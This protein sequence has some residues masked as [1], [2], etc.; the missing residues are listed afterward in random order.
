MIG[1]CGS[2][3]LGSRKKISRQHAEQR[4]LHSWMERQLRLF[5]E[6]QEIAMAME[7]QR[8]QNDHDLLD[9]VAK[10]VNGAVRAIADLKRQYM[11]LLMRNDVEEIAEEALAEELT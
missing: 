10:I 4:A 5:D 2:E 3:Y 11:L 1:V 7:E 6:Q 9:S 8:E